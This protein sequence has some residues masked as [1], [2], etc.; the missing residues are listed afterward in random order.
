MGRILMEN[1]GIQ[2][3][4]Q[5]NITPS[6][7]APAATGLVAGAGVTHL[8]DNGSK[9]RFA[10]KILSVDTVDLSALNDKEKKLLE[11]MQA[12]SGKDLNLAKDSVD[13]GGYK[14][15]RHSKI[16]EASKT[17]LDNAH[18]YVNAVDEMTAVQNKALGFY[19]ESA[20]DPHKLIG[21]KWAKGDTLFND[22]F[23][24][25]IPEPENLLSELD[26]LVESS[27]ERVKEAA[28][29]IR[30]HLN[31]NFNHEDGLVPS[32]FGVENAN[33]YKLA[34]E[35][36]EKLKPQ[37]SEM[38]LYEASQK[39]NDKES[40]VLSEILSKKTPEE[41]AE[42]ITPNSTVSDLKK[43]LEQLTKAEN[44]DD[45]GKKALEQTQSIL[46]E[47]GEKTVD[48]KEAFKNSVKEL[49]GVKD[50]M[51]EFAK[52]IDSVH[53][54][55]ISAVKKADF[56]SSLVK[57]LGIGAVVAVA[58]GTLAYFANNKKEVQETEA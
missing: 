20:N 41:L 6:V 4:K 57:K 43:S 24:G 11:K 52:N 49:P 12:K 33:N 40:Q 34:K 1:N 13:V 36:C 45:K 9:N 2:T 18:N 3:Q 5:S 27:D 37:S 21:G 47:V 10:Q 8:L 30:S 15:L 28:T 29:T 22:A 54:K 39:L 51:E 58:A 48:E 53:G 31:A 38:Y 25:K 19:I 23:N 7:V 44:L 17:A 50:A 56:S 14:A 42:G 32:L 26:K 46:K 35:K 55:V 16:T